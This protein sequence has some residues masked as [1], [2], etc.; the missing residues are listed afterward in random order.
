[1][2]V[3]IVI[4]AYN[5][6]KTIAGVINRVKKFGDVIVVDDCSI[7]A[8]S[9]VAKKSGASV[10][11]HA[12]NHGL[13]GALRTGFQ[14]AMAKNYDAVV[15]LDADGQHNPEDVPKFIAKINEGYDFVLGKRSLKKYPFVKKFG[16]FF[17]NRLTNLISGT[18]LHDTESGFRAIRADA[19]KK[20]RLN[21]ERYEIAVEIVYECGKNKLKC[22]NI[23][24]DSPVYRKGVGFWDGISNFNYLLKKKFSG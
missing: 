9:E 3:G 8:T 18:S 1:M 14:Q 21:A 2:K 16:N 22:A 6:E 5:E 11:R 17:L 19:L 10:I 4:P 15:T 7:D 24:I 20:F 12:K 23:D 13:G